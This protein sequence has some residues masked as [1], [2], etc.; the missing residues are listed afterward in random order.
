MD[1]SDVDTHLNQLQHEI[2]RQLDERKAK[3]RKLSRMTA[4]LQTSSE[5]TSSE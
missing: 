2:E 4:L 5:I 3:S 1:E